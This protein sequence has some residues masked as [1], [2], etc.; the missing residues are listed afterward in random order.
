M[1]SYFS[2]SSPMGVEVIT[3]PNEISDE[4][5]YAIIASLDMSKGRL[6]DDP[7]GI[8]PPPV[9]R[10]SSD[11]VLKRTDESPFESY[12][13]LL[14]SSTTTIPIP[15]VRKYVTWESDIWVFME[16]VEGCTLEEAWPSL[17]IT[18]KLWIAWKLRGYIR[19]LRRVPLPTPR[20]PGPVDG[21]GQPRRCVGCYFSGDLGAGP[22]A[23]YKELVAWYDRKADLAVR[24]DHRLSQARGQSPSLSSDSLAFD[25]TA[26]LVLT[27]GDIALRNLILGNDGR[28]WLID[29]GFSGVY[30][31]SF[32][33]ACMATYRN[34]SA[35]RLWRWLIPFMAGWYRSQLSYLQSLTEALM[36]YGV[37]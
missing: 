37:E 31:Q 15:K 30:P 20:I 34:N 28:L 33:Y 5:A 12:T 24:I 19:Q 10:I 22:F 1:G 14:V 13:M 35:P 21:S 6:A 11:T 3:P 29:W 8:Y 32:E 4:E 18:T 26:P 9:W 2:R 36:L 16:Y 27:H 17:R 23:S 25:D 7:D